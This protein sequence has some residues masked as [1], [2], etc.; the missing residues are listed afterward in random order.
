MRSS[1]VLPILLFLCGAV[2]QAQSVP[3]ATALR[4]RAG[5]AVRLTVQDD[6]TLAGEFAVLSDGT[7][8]L[9]LIGLVPVT[10]A[11]FDE[12]AVR[13]RTAYA[14]E[15]A[16]QAVVLE[17]L[18]R[19]VLTGEVRLPGVLLADPTYDWSQLIARAGG[20][21]P[22]AARDRVLLIRD[23]VEHELRRNGRSLPATPGIRSGDELIVPRRGWVLDNLP[24]LLGSATSVLAAAV[25][26]LL[27]R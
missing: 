9:P 8:L 16:G 17:P 1:L 23:G 27:V 22:S 4:L 18:L 2:V 10:D 26:A 24:I 11:S 21:T 14:R 3:A 6:L 25:T 7:V 5:D 12:V 15:L 19:V 20:E 13:I